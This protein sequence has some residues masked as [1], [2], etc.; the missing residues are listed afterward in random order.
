M[1]RNKNPMLAFLLSFLPGAGHLYLGRWFRAFLYGSFFGFPLMIIAVN[2]L[3]RSRFDPDV[4]AVCLFVSVAAG[5]LNLIDMV[6][7]LLRNPHQA[8]T[9][10]Y[11]PSAGDEGAVPPHSAA[12]GDRIVILLLSFIPGL[13]HFQLGLMQRGIVFLVGYFGIAAMIVFVVA[14]SGAEGFFAF[15]VALPVIWIYG[16]A[17]VLQLQKRKERGETLTDRT[18]FDDFQDMREEGRKSKM[19]ATLLAVFP[20]AGHMYLGLFKR[21]VQLMASFLFAVY[22]LDALHLSLFLFVIPIL[23]FYSFFDALQWVSKHGREPLDDVPFVDWLKHRQK[24]VGFAL[25]LLG[26]YYLLDQALLGLMDRLFPDINFAFWMTRYLQPTIVSALLV[27][28]GIK[29]MRG[30]KV[31]F[32]ASAGPERPTS[33]YG[34]TA[35]SEQPPVSHGPAAS[36]SPIALPGP[37]ADVHPHHHQGGE[38]E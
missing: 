15:L 12:A 28:G 3:S 10:A 18:I 33:S 32:R 23:W 27:F 37:A 16:L 22:F 19:I 1:D 21:G 29:L 5:V 24:W 30:Q 26:V 14:V 20:G 2:A 17:D 7:T 38:K 34:E 6:V 25:V 8:P 35:D 13:G 36:G 11:R 4:F 9:G 31:K